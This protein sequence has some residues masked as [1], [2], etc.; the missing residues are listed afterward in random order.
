MK[1]IKLSKLPVAQPHVTG[2]VS[3]ISYSLLMVDKVHYTPYY[4]E[5][6]VARL[7][8]KI[9]ELGSFDVCYENDPVRPVL[10]NL[11]AIRNDPVNYKLY[12]TE[13][14]PEELPESPMETEGVM[15]IEEATFELSSDQQAVM[16]I[17]EVYKAIDPHNETLYIYKEVSIKDVY[18][19]VIPKARHM[20]KKSEIAFATWCSKRKVSFMDVQFTRKRSREANR[21]YRK[22]YVMNNE[23]R[24]NLIKNIVTSIPRYQTHINSL[25]NQECT[26]IGY[27]RR[28][29]DPSE[30]RKKKRS[31]SAMVQDLKERSM[32]DLVFVSWSCSHADTFASRD[33]P[34]RGSLINSMGGVDGDTQSMISHINASEKDI[35][36]VA[37][38]FKG[39]STNTDDLQNL[40]NTHKNLAA[41]IIDTLHLDHTFHEF[42]REA[43][44]NDPT[45]LSPFAIKLQTS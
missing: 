20:N 22:V 8:K 24:D 37:I 32:C 35:C 15:E 26:I 34:D 13:E 2:W 16:F 44:L 23:H 17:N 28:S 42:K 4:S 14:A 43:V 33:V 10:V 5:E 3:S 25:K 45:I 9:E 41:V 27:A 30:R 39:L 40:F 12:V 1:N 19:S 11:N 38:D 29:F 21:R 6:N 31:L 18:D 36:L 7:S